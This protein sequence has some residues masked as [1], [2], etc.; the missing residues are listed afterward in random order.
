MLRSSVDSFGGTAEEPNYVYY[1]ATLINGST[2]SGAVDP[3]IV[4]TEVRDVPL[5]KD[6]SKYEYS[7]I[8]FNLNGSGRDLPIH[9]MPIKEGAANPTL[10]VNRSVYTASL[11]ANVSYDMSGTICTATLTSSQDLIYVPE[12]LDPAQAPAPAP[13]TTQTGQQVNTRYYWVYTVSHFLSMLNA[14]YAAAKADIQAQFA[15]AW[16]AQGCTGPAPTL[17]TAAP[18]FTWDPSTKLFTMYADRQGFGGAD[19]LSAGTVKDEDWHVYMN[20]SLFYLFANYDN[21]Y[22]NQGEL[23]NELLVKN[24]LYQNIMSVASPPAAAAKSYWVVTQDY[25]STSALWS[26]VESIV[27]CSNTLPIVAEA[28]GEPVRFGAGNIGSPQGTQGGFSRVITDIALTQDSAFS[29]RDFI[30]YVPSGEYRVCSFQ[31]TQQPIQNIDIS[32]FFKNRLDG[33]LYP[34]QMPN[35]SSVSIKLMLRRKGL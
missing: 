16:V 5:I 30:S 26:P 25:P 19:R 8:R 20:S 2:Q 9:I 31:A 22:I 27:F 4:F 18:Q 7:I 14:A 34:L 33:K 32:V 24:L 23:T 10:D 28:S 13:S 3:P 17:Q 12:T 35:S 15:A 29:Y 1:S 21:Q 11:R 6:S